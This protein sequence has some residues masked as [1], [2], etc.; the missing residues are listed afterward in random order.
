MAARMGKRPTRPEKREKVAYELPL[1]RLAMS[2][3]QGDD[4]KALELLTADDL[5]NYT[6]VQTRFVRTKISGTSW[7][8]RQYVDDLMLLE[9]FISR[10]VQGCASSLHYHQLKSQYS[11][12]Y[13]RILHELRPDRVA[14]E[15]RE[16]RAQEPEARRFARKLEARRK[17][18]EAE[19]RKSWVEM[20][21][22]LEGTKGGEVP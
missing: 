11:Q 10:G 19:S 17:R 7:S 5:S 4:E 14:K 20:G 21:G 3:S 9:L 2:L 6:N 22:R 1:Y 16:R 8:N 13:E 12:E 15:E 18:E